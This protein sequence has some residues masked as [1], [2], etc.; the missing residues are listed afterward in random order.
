MLM[1]RCE[2][3]TVTEVVKCVSYCA[4]SD[5]PVFQ[6]RNNKCRWLRDK[7]AKTKEKKNGK[8]Y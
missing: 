4:I 3:N 7:P 2:G 6:Q 1:K 5:W 8:I